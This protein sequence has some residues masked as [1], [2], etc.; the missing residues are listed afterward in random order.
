MEIN[1]LYIF[2]KHRKEDYLLFYNDKKIP[3]FVK[4]SIQELRTQ[5][6]NNNLF[7]NKNSHKIPSI[8][9][10]NIIYENIKYHLIVKFLP[11]FFQE[12]YLFFDENNEDR[13]LINKKF[14]KYYETSENYYSL[15]SEHN[16]RLLKNDNYEIEYEDIHIDFIILSKIQK[17]I[18]NMSLSEKEKIMW[19]EHEI[20]IVV[21]E[22]LDFVSIEGVYP[23]KVKYTDKTLLKIINSFLKLKF[24]YTYIKFLKEN[25]NIPIFKKLLL[26]LNSIKDKTKYNKNKNWLTKKRLRLYLKEKE[27]KHIEKN[28]KKLFYNLNELLKNHIN[29]DEKEIKIQFLQ[30]DKVWEKRVLK[31]TKETSIFELETFIEQIEKTFRTETFNSVKIGS[32]SKPDLESTNYLI[33]SKF[34]ILNENY[35][36]NNSEDF[37]KLLRDLI[38][39]NKKEGFIILVKKEGTNNKYELKEENIGGL[40]IKILEID[41]FD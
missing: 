14:N 21:E 24:N 19:S 6:T 41:F 13:K 27:I 11:I 40:K 29:I 35:L 32:N 25:I 20:G 31:Y 26:K 34:K 3:L 18:K 10:K 36:K 23:Q 16:I 4:N 33:D 28:N 2:L 15:K 17:L 12:S 22:L 5:L 30:M 39:F 9:V 38:V 37:N 1:T 8:V 7:S